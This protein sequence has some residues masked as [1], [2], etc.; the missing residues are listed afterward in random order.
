MKKIW[1]FY[2]MNVN[3]LVSDNYGEIEQE[4]DEDECMND[5]MNVNGE[6]NNDDMN[7]NDESVKD[8]MNDNDEF[9]NDHIQV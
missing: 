4:L 5:D 8:D 1:H 2:A 3:I 7:D 9:I 6:F